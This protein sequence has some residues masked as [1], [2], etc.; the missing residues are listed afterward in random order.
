MILLALIATLAVA[1]SNA[2]DCV[3]TKDEYARLVRTREG[4]GTTGTRSWSK[5]A[6]PGKA[7][8]TYDMQLGNYRRSSL[9]KT[10]ALSLFCLAL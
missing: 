5:T 7:C 6:E 9:I 8:M 2:G 1:A 10:F 3:T 4:P